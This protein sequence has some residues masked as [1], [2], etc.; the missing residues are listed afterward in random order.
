MHCTKI[1]LK[2]TLEF[3]SIRIFFSFNK[4]SVG[5]SFERV[6]NHVSLG[7]SR[8]PRTTHSSEYHSRLLKNF[9]LQL[10]IKNVRTF[11]LVG[12]VKTAFRTEVC[13]DVKTTKAVSLHS[14]F[15]CQ[16]I[17]TPYRCEGSVH[18]G[19]QNAKKVIQKA[20]P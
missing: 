14:V 5:F 15:E 12:L 4:F 18:I 1:S 11:T 9:I 10:I 3:Y 6:F 17:K 19:I 16:L 8:T 7:T 20:F 2:Q 13:L